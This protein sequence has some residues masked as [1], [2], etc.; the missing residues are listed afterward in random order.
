MTSLNQI[1]NQVEE[2]LKNCA[3]SI[4]KMRKS[5]RG[6][7]DR[8]IES[9][10]K[11]SS[12]KTF[13]ATCEG[14]EIIFLISLYLSSFDPEK[15]F[16]QIPSL[17]NC[18]SKDVKWLM[19]EVQKKSHKFYSG[20]PY[21]G[22]FDRGIYDCHNSSDALVFFLAVCIHALE[23]NKECNIR[24]SGLS[25]KDLT[26]CIERALEKLKEINK[27]TS[28][29]GWPNKIGD[30]TPDIYATW[31]VIETL[32]ELKYFQEDLYNAFI[33]EISLDKI[34]QWLES[35]LKSVFDDCESIFYTP[36]KGEDIEGNDA[37]CRQLACIHN[38]LHLVTSLCILEK[39]N[40]RELGRRV[41][42]I[43]NEKAL[44]LYADF[45]ARYQSGVV[46]Y[47]LI[48]LLLRCLSSIFC[49]YHAGAVGYRDFIS[50]LGALADFKDNIMYDCLTELLLN[51]RICKKGE[52]LY[53]FG[54]PDPKSLFPDEFEYYYTERTVESLVAYLD[55]LYEDAVPKNID[56]IQI[57]TI[58]DRIE[59]PSITVRPDL[60]RLNALE[61]YSGKLKQKYGEV[62][63]DC[64][65]ICLL[66]FLDDLPP[67]I[68]QLIHLGAKGNNIF[69]LRKT[70]GYP[71]GDKI[72]DY[73][74]TYIGC[75]TY[76]QD[77]L[78]DNK[79]KIRRKILE[80]AINICDKNRYQKIII[81][82]DGGYFV[83]L[84]HKEFSNKIQHCLGAVE[85]TTRGLRNDQKIGKTNLKI[86]II[87]VARSRLKSDI[88]APE[89][90]ETL[91]S[92]VKNICASNK[93]NFHPKH[94][95][96]LVLGY[97][98]I[99]RF[100]VEK[101]AS[102][103]FNVTI[104]DKKKQRRDEARNDHKIKEYKINV[105]ESLERGELSDFK[106]IIGITGYTS[107][108]EL[109]FLKFRH[110]VILASGSSERYEIDF[111]SLE[112]LVKPP[113]EKNVKR[114]DIKFL[115]NYHL[116]NGNIVR[117]L[118]DGEPI[119]FPLSGGI[120]PIT[121]E[122]VLMQLLWGAVA[123]AS[124]YKKSK[125]GIKKFPKSEEEK[126]MEI[127]EALQ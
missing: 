55:Y 74:E 8:Y 121:I 49:K 19:S 78:D 44:I 85:Q 27:S 76:L 37:I 91:S 12:P 36:P 75:K 20:D 125:A 106:F 72:Q 46:D 73:L 126:I 105:L 101:L 38:A 47:T 30:A 96:I 56:T 3:F 40:H 92:N 95:K 68:N 99:G 60:A 107:I 124:I 21:Y 102:K 94:T 26:S 116:R 18:I 59:R 10:L 29:K 90:A 39:G 93:I 113:K 63:K 81:I 80:D 109:N 9:D 34:G 51:K 77:L 53:L 61:I 7:W 15:I 11:R 23:W 120:P 69:L 6:F 1:Q 88:E 41:S 111:E 117:I 42:T 86:P 24:F 14:L 43:I 57:K 114:G 122:P 62:F 83:P 103:G 45:P 71:N 33:G 32:D 65:L 79:L 5:R 123:V 87:N 50:G 100:L 2:S 84:L 89:V 115:T 108:K 31:S 82:E 97:G 127:F 52:Y 67:F 112:Q 118:C 119:N 22:V 98:H 16:Q 17:S 28:N 48:P 35:Q 70:Y 4:G 54:D 104:Y 66:H 25:D 13:V 58:P 110:N 64:V